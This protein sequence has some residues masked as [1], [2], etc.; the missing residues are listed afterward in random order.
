M[1]SIKPGRGPSL[2]SLI[3]SAAACLFGVFWTI[4]AVNIGAPVFFPLFGLIFIGIGIFEIWYSYHNLTSENRFSTFDITDDTEESDPL[5]D[6]F[7][8]KKAST[9][10][11]AVSDN[12]SKNFCPY[13]GAPMKED[14]RFC[15]N[16]GA[17]RD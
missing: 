15:E 4:L 17:E 11:K 13:C 1:K 9:H 5:N 2:Q 12:H 10:E 7:G 16:C 6:R 8:H 14:H 3:G